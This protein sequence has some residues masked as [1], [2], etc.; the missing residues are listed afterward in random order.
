MENH[1]SL[2]ASMVFIDNL[3]LET[4]KSIRNNRQRTHQPTI[5]EYIQ[6]V[7]DISE[8]EIEERLKSLIASGKIELT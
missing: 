7:K 6:K 1:D 5:T 8:L 4:I 2:D 3:I